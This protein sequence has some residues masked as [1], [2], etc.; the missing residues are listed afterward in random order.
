MIATTL[1][2]KKKQAR[3]Q[4]LA[5]VGLTSAAGTLVDP[6]L[7]AEPDGTNCRMT[8]L[9]GRIIVAPHRLARLQGLEPQE[10]GWPAVAV[11]EAENRFGGALSTL[12][13]D[14]SG[15]MGVL[16]VELGPADLR[17]ALE[18]NGFRVVP[19]PHVPCARPWVQ[20]ELQALLPVSVFHA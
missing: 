5:Y 9:P 17:W 19:V 7:D 2:S 20:E 10:Y 8:L 11:I 6:R 12:A 15:T 14:L 4:M 16:H 18:Q 1:R 13:I 3:E